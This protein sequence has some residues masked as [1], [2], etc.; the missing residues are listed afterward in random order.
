M[1][2]DNK[3][4]YFGQDIENKNWSVIVHRSAVSF[5]ENR[6]NSSLFPKGREASMRQP[7]IENKFKDMYKDIRTTLL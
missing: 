4:K 1:F 3:F 2:M 5:S 7:K 6:D